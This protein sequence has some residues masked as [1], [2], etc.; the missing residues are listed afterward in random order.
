MSTN[1]PLAV[2]F[3]ASGNSANLDFLRSVA[4]LLVYVTHFH[5]IYTGTA[6]K[7]D[8]FWHIGQLG[9][10]MFFVHTCL[11]L[12]RSLEQSNLQGAELFTTF[13]VRRI[14]RLY[15][16]SIVCVLIAYIIDLHWEPRNLW[17]NLTLTQNL[18]FTKQ[19]VF[20][21]ILTPLW[22]LPLEMQMYVALPALFL[23]LRR[24]PMKL[25]AALWLMSLP[26]AIIQPQL[27]ERFEILKFAPCFLGGI[28]A[29]C[30]TGQRTISRLSG[31]LW[32]FA[33]TAVSIIWMTSTERYLPL[34]IAGFGV[35]LGIAIPCFHEIPWPKVQTVSRV[36]A[37]YSYG[38]YLSHF[39]IQLF[40][41]TS[42]E[43]PHFRVIHQLP[44]LLHFARPV[45]LALCFGLSVLIPVL[46]YHFL[47]SPGI[48]LG[49]RVS[50][51]LVR[52]K[53]QSNSP[54]LKAESGLQI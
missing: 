46:L 41:F 51:W 12:M 28:V 36:I 15:P 18:F 5:G 6:V 17:P 49:Q 4:V 39:A 40:C 47:E 21:P 25:L 24:R 44:R 2:Q 45:H 31:W 43:Y 22:S 33:I 38:I 30:L 14:F 35:C 48:R 27:G 26:L 32:P 54:V 52:S 13:Y 1:S 16:L 42:P 34:H 50:C 8:F 7:W 37:R 10:L 29:W 3:A 9:V 19:P 53:R 23:L 20:P 11:V